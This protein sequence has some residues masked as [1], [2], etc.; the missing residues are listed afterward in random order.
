VVI[1][2]S[3]LIYPGTFDVVLLNEV[4]EYVP[5]DDIVLQESYRIL[6]GGGALIV[7]SPNRLFPF[8]I[9]GIFARKSNYKIPHYIQ[10]IPYIPLRIGKYF[11]QY[12][13]RNY[14]PWELRKKIT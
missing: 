4:L 5:N 11:F 12:W 10:F 1:F 14:Y 2:S 13:A 6:R 3:F 9:H 7:F 8:E